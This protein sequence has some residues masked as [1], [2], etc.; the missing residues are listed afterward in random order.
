MRYISF[1]SFLPIKCFSTLAIFETA[2]VNRSQ[3]PTSTNRGKQNREVFHAVPSK[4]VSFCLFRG[5]AMRART[6]RAFARRAGQ[7]GSFPDE[8]FLACDG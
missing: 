4:A 8:R 7:R 1:C 6:I 2:R 3:R 5:N